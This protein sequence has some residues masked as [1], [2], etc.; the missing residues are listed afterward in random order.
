MLLN[1]WNRSKKDLGRKLEWIAID[2]YNTDQNHLHFCIRGI[3]KEGLEVRIDKGYIKEGARR[4]SKQLL[5]QKLGLRTDDYIIERR[6]K[7]LEVKHVTE[8]DRIIEN[9]LNLTVSKEKIIS[10]KSQRSRHFR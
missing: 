5:T 6:E 7:T 8:L 2:H 1:S 4:I 3:D 10:V 9:E